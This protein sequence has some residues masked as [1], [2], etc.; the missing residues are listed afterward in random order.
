MTPGAN[1]SFDAGSRPTDIRRHAASIDERRCGFGVF[2]KASA[3][4]PD[5]PAINRAFLRFTD[6]GGTLRGETSVGV[7]SR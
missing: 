5:R 7:R 4:G 1:R 2:L 6:S 3:I